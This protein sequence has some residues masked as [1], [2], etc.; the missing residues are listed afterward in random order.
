M[1]QKGQALM[2]PFQISPDMAEKLGTAS[3]KLTTNCNIKVRHHV[4]VMI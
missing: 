4:R 3:L 1:I 2:V